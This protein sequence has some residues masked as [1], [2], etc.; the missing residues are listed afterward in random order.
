MLHWTAAATATTERLHRWLPWPYSAKQSTSLLY[1]ASSPLQGQE[2]ASRYAF[3][4]AL[5]VEGLT[6]RGFTR[7]GRKRGYCGDGTITTGRGSRN[8]GGGCAVLRPRARDRFSAQ[9]RKMGR[10]LKAYILW[11]CFNF[12]SICFIT[13][14]KQ[15]GECS[16]MFSFSNWTGY[17]QQ[18][19]GSILKRSPSGRT[20]LLQ[21]RS[22][23]G[24]GSGPKTATSSCHVAEAHQY[25]V[26]PLG[27][28]MSCRWRNRILL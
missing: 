6:S 11:F 28:R 14:L 22:R 5:K 12:V 2:G 16:S 4:G 9:A 25:T 19:T 3:P 8:I 13:S 27:L 23:S 21:S 7:S 20:V 26:R 24:C 17:Q 18:S 15:T 10:S 1:N